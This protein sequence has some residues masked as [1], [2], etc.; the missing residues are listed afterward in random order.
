MKN[1]WRISNCSDQRG[2]R[3]WSD[4]GQDDVEMVR[5]GRPG[6]LTSE[7]AGHYYVFGLTTMSRIGL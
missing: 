5:L 1:G 4:A 3:A 2:R 6:R 7:D